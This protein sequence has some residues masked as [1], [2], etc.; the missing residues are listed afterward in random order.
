MKNRLYQITLVAASTLVLSAAMHN[1][2]LQDMIY[3]SALTGGGVLAGATVQL[4]NF[5][6]AVTAKR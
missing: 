4:G 3:D 2:A 1:D 6:Q 5:G